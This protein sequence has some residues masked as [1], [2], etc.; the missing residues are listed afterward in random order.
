MYVRM[1]NGNIVVCMLL[2]SCIGQMNVTLHGPRSYM[3]MGRQ[4]VPS[5]HNRTD[6]EE[7]T[8]LIAK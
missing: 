1:K 8:Q 6:F 4:T 2:H 5:C 7:I 3:K